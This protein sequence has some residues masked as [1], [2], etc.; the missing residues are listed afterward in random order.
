MPSCA[1]PSAG[2]A[3]GSCLQ[4]LEQVLGRGAWGDSIKACFIATLEWRYI[5]SNRIKHEPGLPRR[6]Q[7]ED[8]H[9]LRTPFTH[10]LFDFH[11]SSKIVPIFIPI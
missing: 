7:R 4:L 2:E 3:L 11:F 8:D 9:D 5:A 1:G 10:G 6:P